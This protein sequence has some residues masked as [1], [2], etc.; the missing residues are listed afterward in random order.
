MP[1]IEDVRAFLTQRNALPKESAIPHGV[2]FRCKG[3]EVINWYEKKGNLVVQGTATALSSQIKSW[4]ET[5]NDP[6]STTVSPLA[7]G[8]TSTVIP[9]LLPGLSKDI[10]VVYGHDEPVRDQLELLLRRMGLNP[11]ILARITGGGDTIIEKLDKYLGERSNVGFAC[12]LLTPDDEGN[13]AG[14]PEDKKYRARQNVILELGMVLARLGRRNTAILHKKSIELPS[15]I[16]GLIYIPFQERVDEVR[17]DLF[18]HLEEAGFK[19][20]ADGL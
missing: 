1:T 11:I 12:V 8:N 7:D 13:K 15:D 5:G 18:R 3:G 14:H 6:A 19:P 9:A 20:K 2:S 17:T 10:F 4:A 16:S